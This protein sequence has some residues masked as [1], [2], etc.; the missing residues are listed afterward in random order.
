MHIYLDETCLGVWTHLLLSPSCGRC[1]EKAV[2]TL[3]LAGV[4]N[5]VSTYPCLSCDLCF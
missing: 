4:E 1:A 5:N 2:Y 3:S